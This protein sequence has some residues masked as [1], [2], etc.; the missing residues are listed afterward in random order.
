MSD[1]ELITELSVRLNWNKQDIETMLVALGDIIGNKL[2]NND[3]IN[4]QGLGLFEARKKAER[5][6]ANPANNKRYL[7]PPKQV[8]VFRPAIT[9]KNYLKTLD[10]NG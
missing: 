1:I 7:I 6:S 4:M 10:K 8:A 2:A 3:L 9:I 5:F